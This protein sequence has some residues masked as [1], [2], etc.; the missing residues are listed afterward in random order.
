MGVL[1]K[2]TIGAGNRLLRLVSMRQYARGF[3]SGNT[4]GI[5]SILAVLLPLS[6]AAEELPP[7]DSS[8]NIVVI[9]VDDLSTDALVELPKDQHPSKDRHG[10]QNVTGKVR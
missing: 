3:V 9:M 8:P 10:Y 1:Q 5:L 2:F 4:A 7:G 6:A